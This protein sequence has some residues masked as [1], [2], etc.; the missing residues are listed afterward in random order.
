MGEASSGA[1][2][3]LEDIQSQLSDEERK[4]LLAANQPPRFVRGL[5]STEARVLEPF[6][7]TIQGQYFQFLRIYLQMLK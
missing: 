6:K 1:E 4:Q 3:T 5:K 7:L 2:L